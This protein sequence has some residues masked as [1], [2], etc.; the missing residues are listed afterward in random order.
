M[1]PMKELIKRTDSASL[2]SIAEAISLSISNDYQG[3]VPFKEP[4]VN[5]KKES[6]KIL[7]DQE[8]AVMDAVLDHKI[9]LVG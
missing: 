8:V 5:G 3:L 7:T 2:Q 6:N 9:T 4:K 1:G